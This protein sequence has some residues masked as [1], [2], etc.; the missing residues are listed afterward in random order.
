MGP[1]SHAGGSQV[2]GTARSGAKD[3]PKAA[4]RGGPVC[5]AVAHGAHG[6]GF[7]QQKWWLFQ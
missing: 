1:G 7:R 3:G 4:G 6:M 2:A 5:P